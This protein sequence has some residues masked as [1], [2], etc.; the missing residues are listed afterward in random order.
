VSAPAVVPAA[1]VSLV[2][3]PVPV[4]WEGVSARFFP[5]S[6]ALVRPEGFSAVAGA[7]SV[8]FAALPGVAA[9]WAEELPGRGWGVVVVAVSR[10]GRV[11]G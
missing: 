6:P 8:A 11:G 2:L 1:F 4:V 9:A 3:G 5:V 7:A 10:S